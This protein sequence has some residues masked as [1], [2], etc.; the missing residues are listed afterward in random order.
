MLW[1][2]SARLADPLFSAD[3]IPQ[4]I[5]ALLVVLELI[6][7]TIIRSKVTEESSIHN[8]EA[9]TIFW[10]WRST[11]PKFITF[12]MRHKLYDFEVLYR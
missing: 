11:P 1:L 12:V 3:T 8:H 6:M 7:H 2:P 9:L 10:P 5:T 4:I